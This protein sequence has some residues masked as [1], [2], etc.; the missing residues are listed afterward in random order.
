MAKDV[1]EAAAPTERA[2]TDAIDTRPARLA[3]LAA[4][5]E[6]EQALGDL[7]EISVERVLRWYGESR[8]ISPKQAGS[9]VGQVPPR[10]FSDPAEL[11]DLA[12]PQTGPERAL[13]AAYWWQVIQGLE[14]FDS[15][16]INADLKNFGFPSRNIT[17]DF[18]KLVARQ[19][20]E[21][22]QVRKDGRSNQARKRYRL[23][24]EG[25]KHVELM[26]RSG[27]KK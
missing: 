14:D 11:F 25:I 27:E 13:V 19:P 1:G 18:T 5:H 2:V 8:G 12:D 22:R 24:R 4:L 16:R 9:T 21:V 7:P 26:L 17:A 10:S 6:L 3:E 20:S 15:Q 23:T